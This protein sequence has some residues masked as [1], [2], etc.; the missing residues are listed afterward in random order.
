MPAKVKKNK[1]LPDKIDDQ[2]EQDI[3]QAKP[4]VPKKFKTS[5]ELKALIGVNSD[6]KVG[7]YRRLWSYLKDNKRQ[8]QGDKRYFIPDQA[9]RSIFGQ[10][11]IPCNRMMR[12]VTKQH[13]Q[14]I[15]REQDVEKT[16]K[17]KKRNRR[18]YP[19]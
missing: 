14:P 13:L 18:L 6:T 9:M 11:R 17:K 12:Y 5:N 19:Y 16:K 10:G 3:I 4:H 8:C 7:V 15:K 1:R 2:R